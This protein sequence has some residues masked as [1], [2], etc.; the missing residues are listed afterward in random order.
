MTNRE[1]LTRYNTELTTLN[2]E[3]YQQQPFGQ[4]YVHWQF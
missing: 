2:Q 4:Q 3:A 1:L